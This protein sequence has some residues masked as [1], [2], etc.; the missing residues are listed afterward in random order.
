MVRSACLVLALV[1]CGSGSSTATKS[2]G[3]AVK[4][5]EAT[6]S[7]LGPP[8]TPVMKLHADGTSEFLERYRHKAPDWQPGFTLAA[9]GSFTYAGKP[10]GRSLADEFDGVV[11]GH[12]HTSK[13][14]EGDTV[15]IDIQ[16]LPT[17]RFEL[18]ADQTVTLTGRPAD[19]V[20]RWRIDA[21]D[22]D[23]ARTAFLVFAI[24]MKASID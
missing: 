20:Q 14:L 9:D 17:A 18:A 22:H 16:G 2:G 12:D 5:G 13:K 3:I 21:P 11:S 15:V 1:A 4:L 7:E 24:W 6:V 8:E 19:K 23:V 10:L